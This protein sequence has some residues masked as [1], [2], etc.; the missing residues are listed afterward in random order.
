M[1]LMIESRVGSTS[2]N[3]HT[4]V[5][6]KVN[7]YNQND[8]SLKSLQKRPG[9]SLGQEILVEEELAGAPDSHKIT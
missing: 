3:D 6:T 2:S 1:C 9:S 7:S 4:D 8:P 5:V